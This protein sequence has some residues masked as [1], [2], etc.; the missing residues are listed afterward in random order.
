MKLTIY[1]SIEDPSN[2]EL[3]LQSLANQA[4]AK[5][6][7]SYNIN[8]ESHQPLIDFKGN[9]IGFVKLSKE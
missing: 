2:F 4:I 5:A 8:D 7:D 9:H 3:Q 6:I 1:L